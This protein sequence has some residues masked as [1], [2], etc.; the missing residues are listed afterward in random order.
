MVLVCLREIVVP[1]RGD[2]HPL[3]LS[4]HEQNYI[5]IKS[6]E[7]QAVEG[8]NQTM[9][10]YVLVMLWRIMQCGEEFCT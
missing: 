1:H 2:L 6:T 8:R 9:E 4:S 5:I 7:Y 3:G 10:S